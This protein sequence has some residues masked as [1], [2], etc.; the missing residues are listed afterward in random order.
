[1]FEENLQSHPRV[2]VIVLDFGVAGDW[3]ALFSA[4]DRQSFKDF[5]VVIVENG[6][7]L[8][9]SNLLKNN[10]IRRVKPGR[11]LGFAGGVDAGIIAA[12]GEY[13]V[14]LND[15]AVPEATWLERLVGALEVD[16]KIGAVCSKVLFDRVYAR[17]E[18]KA[19]TF[20]P[21][22][23]E[24]GVSDDRELGIRIALEKESTSKC[25]MLGVHGVEFVDG[26]EWVWTKG[27]A[28]LWLPVDEVGKVRLRLDSHP[29]QSGKSLKIKWGSGAC[30]CVELD[31]RGVRELVFGSDIV[32]GTYLVNNAGSVIQEDW[33]VLERGLYEP[34]DGRYDEAIDLEAASACSLM[35]RRS[36]LSGEQLFDPEFFAYYED[37]DLSR[38]LR[39]SGYRIVYEPKS[40]VYHKRSGTAGTQSAFQVFHATRN[41]FWVIAKHAPWKVVW[42]A[43]WGEMRNLDW[44]APW[45]NEEFSLSRL[46]RETWWGFMKR[47][48]CRLT[49]AE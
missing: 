22:L 5:E 41:R 47:V 4:F 10:E 45:L 32:G 20:I 26:E 28:T 25:L 24:R 39:E 37:V 44:Y 14:L 1:M 13:F 42:G 15:D 7:P 49:D 8:G 3:P 23:V 17:C 43:M 11:N 46:K 21:S 40:R 33:N 12:K 16:I 18:V 2:S 31:G 38:R 34:D 19:P 36:A 9:I 35:V 29:V 6:M 30:D 48:W 27:Q